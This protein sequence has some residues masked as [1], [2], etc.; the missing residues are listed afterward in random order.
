MRNLPES[1]RWY[2]KQDDVHLLDHLLIWDLWA[3]SANVGREDM[4]L[5]VSWVAVVCIKVFDEASMP[6]PDVDFVL[7]VAEMI[8]KTASKVA[9]AE[10]EDFGF[11]R[12]RQGHVYFC[13]EGACQQG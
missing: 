5:Q 3:Y 9:C 12:R 7:R 11:R 1:L 4:V 13:H 8:C 10:H 2:R 6:G